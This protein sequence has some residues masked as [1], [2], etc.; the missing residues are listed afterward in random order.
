MTQALPG[1]QDLS[2]NDAHLREDLVQG[3]QVY[4]GHFLDVRRDEV[5]LPDGSKAGRE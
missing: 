2:D 5:R 1:L 4:Q 3:Q